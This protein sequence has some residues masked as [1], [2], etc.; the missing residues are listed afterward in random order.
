ITRSTSVLLS[1]T[2]FTITHCPRKR[3]SNSLSRD[4][5]AA[6]PAAVPVR[7]PLARWLLAVPEEQVR[8][9]LEVD[10]DARRLVDT[11]H[12]TDQRRQP[13]L[14]QRAGH[15]DATPGGRPGVDDAG[16]DSGHDVAAAPADG[17][18]AGGADT[19]PPPR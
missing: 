12:P 5:A 6:E 16:D 15:R 18:P 10:D 7:Q 19:R 2:P 8:R 3:A 13:D 1:A 4:C 14:L 11:T 9:R 17:R